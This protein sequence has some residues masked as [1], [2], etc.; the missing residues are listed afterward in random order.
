VGLNIPQIEL[1]A[2]WVGGMHCVIVT[3]LCCA[4]ICGVGGF[5]HRW[6][7]TTPTTMATARRDATPL[8]PQRPKLHQKRQP[9]FIP[10]NI[11]LFLC[12]PLRRRFQGK[13]LTFALKSLQKCPKFCPAQKGVAVQ[14]APVLLSDTTAKI[15]KKSDWGMFKPTLI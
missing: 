5:K 1:L 2:I 15:A 11:Y 10:P 8:T 13:C 14:R 7:T 3:K 12:M 9:Q 4:Q 6:A